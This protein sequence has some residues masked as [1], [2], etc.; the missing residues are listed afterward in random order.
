MRVCV[1]FTISYS[2]ITILFLVLFIRRLSCTVL[3]RLVGFFLLL[4]LLL[5]CFLCRQHHR[6]QRRRLRRLHHQRSA[7]I[8]ATTARDFSFL[9][10][11]SLHFVIN[12]F[13]D[14]R[15]ICVFLL[16]CVLFLF[17][18]WSANDKVI[19]CSYLFSMLLVME[20][21]CLYVCQFVR[22]LFPSLFRDRTQTSTKVESLFQFLL[23]FS[24]QILFKLN[25]N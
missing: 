18:T 21:L 3:A 11:M 6:Q 23:L 9:E 13:I 24:S 16:I 22:V 1:C 12:S 15:C 5:C 8:C 10:Q 7:I 17:E 4:L 14:S 19:S 25:L 2:F 20:V